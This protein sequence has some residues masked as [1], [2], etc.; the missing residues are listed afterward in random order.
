MKIVN[1]TDLNCSFIK[2]DSKDFDTSE[3]VVKVKN[4]SGGVAGRYYHSFRGSPLLICRVGKNLVYPYSIK[5]YKRKG[6]QEELVVN[7]RQELLEYIFAHEFM[8]FIQH[9]TGRVASEFETEFYAVS[10]VNSK[11]CLK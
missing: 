3:L 10:K 4:S 8:H 2:E 1:Y 5:L 6:L 11:R 9:K 7:S